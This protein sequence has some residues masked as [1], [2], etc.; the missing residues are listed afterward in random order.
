MSTLNNYIS[1]RP[2]QSEEERLEVYEE[3][4]KDGNRHPLMPTHVV[5]K[6]EDIVGAFC[7]Y[8]PT[9]YWW[10]HTQ[11]VKGRDSFSIFQIMSALLANDGVSKFILP[12][13]PESPYFSLLS[14]KLSHHS[15]TEGGDWRLFINES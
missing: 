12:C 9:V 15:G 1:I 7:L 14:K 11:K 4:D 2:I 5:K 8:S 3:A 6:G 10:M 13:E